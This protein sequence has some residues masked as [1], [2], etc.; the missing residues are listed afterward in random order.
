MTTLL[1]K[2]SFSWSNDTQAT[3]DKLK[4]AIVYALVLALSNFNTTFVVK[5]DASSGGIG[6][7]LS[8]NG[9]PI[10][11]FNRA[12]SPKHQSY[13]VYEREMLAIL[14]AVKKWNSYLLGRH[15]QI[16]TGHESLKFFLDQK[17]HTPAQQ[18]WVI[19]MMNYDYT[20]SFRK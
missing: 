12:L 15:F 9:R 18:L 2:N 10:A 8:Q 19:K 20:L 7:V 17:T 11:Y 4:Q 3:W 1:K 16:R 14:L 6:T 5:S 13:S